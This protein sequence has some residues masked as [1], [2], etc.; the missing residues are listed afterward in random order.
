LHVTVNP[1]QHTNA[2]SNP[3]MQVAVTLDWRHLVS[4]AY[5]RSCSQQTHLPTRPL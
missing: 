1:Q 2:S 5:E 3:R 4:L